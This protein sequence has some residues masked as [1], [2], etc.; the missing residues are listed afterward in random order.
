M[1]KFE[2]V[3][4]LYPNSKVAS[5]KDLDLD[6]EKGEI[7]VIV[8]TSGSGKTTTMKMINRL[9]EPTSGKIYVNG[10]DISKINPIKLRLNIGYVIQ[11]TGL[12]PHM[13]IEENIAV[14]PNEKGWD[15]ERINKRIDE[16]LELVE[17]DPKIYRKKYPKHLSGGQRQRVGVARAL[18]ADPPIM[19]MDEPFGALDPITRRK[20]QD[21]FLHIQEKIC[22]TIVFVTHDI[23]EAIKMGDKIAVMKGGRL[24]QF[25]TPEEIL[26]N[27]ADEFVESL[28]GT[29]STLKMMNLIRCREIM[30][31]VPVVIFDE[32]AEV[33]L[34]KTEN[35]NSKSIAVV[36]DKEKLIGY[37]KRSKIVN[38]KGSIRKM[39][40]SI[41]GHVKE[42]TTLNDTLSEM[43]SIGSKEIFVTDK[44]DH[45]KGVI[46]MDDLLKAVSD[47]E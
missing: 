3:T 24:V 7:C 36:D 12:F 37:V 26:S 27:P 30:R 33:V 31:E 32:D 5:V 6:I 2:K 43:F 21:E 15:K 14:V 18:A 44:N 19:L 17:L 42:N 46:N 39:V 22:K 41:N 23:D 34:R 38:H 9:I 1:I 20:I 10:E 11:G 29:N 16:L 40:K 45:V 25:G 13:T 4:K 8:G 35:K 28:I 47:D